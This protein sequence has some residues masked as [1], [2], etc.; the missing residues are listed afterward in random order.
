MKTI[1][2]IR[3]L[4]VCCLIMGGFSFPVGVQAQTYIDG[5]AE[6]C[7]GTSGNYTIMPSPTPG[8]TYTWNASSNGNITGSNI[9]GNITVSWFSAGGGNVSA[10]GKD[11]SG[12][13]LETLNFPVNV[14]ATPSPHIEWDVRVGCQL[15]DSTKRDKE[16]KEGLAAVAPGAPGEHIDDGP[17]VRVCENSIVKYWVTNPT[18]GPLTWSAPGGTIL[19]AS[20]NTC[21]VQWGS[22][23]YGSV[24]VTE[25]Y[26]APNETCTGTTEI[27]IEI[28]DGPKAAFHAVPESAGVPPDMVI[29]ACV[30]KDIYFVDDSDPD[31]GTPLVSWYWDFGDGTFSS[32]QDPVHAYSNP[33]T[34]EVTL[35][36]TNEC[37]CTS[38]IKRKVEVYPNSEPLVIECPSVVCEGA[39]V[40]YRL[41]NPP[42]KILDCIA[43]GIAYWDVIGG[44]ILTPVNNTFV[45]IRWDNVGPDGFGYVIFNPGADCGIECPAPTVVKVPVILNKGTIEGAIVVCPKGRQ[46]RYSLPQWPATL[47][48]WSIVTGTGAILMPSDQPN[49]IILVTNADGPVTIKATYQ[50]TLL[51]CGGTASIDVQVVP[52]VAIVGPSE[53]CVTDNY[54]F[55]LSTPYFADWSLSGP[56]GFLYTASGTSFGGTFSGGPGSYVL[57]VSGNSFCSPGPF[58]I[59]VLDIPPPPDSISGPDSTCAGIPVTF[60]AGAAAPGTLFEWSVSG[61]TLTGSNTGNEVTAIFNPGGP[62][63]ISVR[64]VTVESPNCPSAYI[65]HTVSIYNPSVTI[66]GTNPVCPNAA[67]NYSASYTDGDTY[68]WFVL[69][70]S[71]GSIASGDNT[72]NVQVLW[73][74][75]T[76]TVSAS[77]VVKMRRCNQ[78]YYDTLPVTVFLQPNIYVT[79]DLTKCRGEVFNLT[80]NYPAGTTFSSVTWTY[81]GGSSTGWPTPSPA[82]SFNNPIGSNTVNTITVTANDPN[83]CPSTVQ[84]TY[85]VTVKPSPVAFISP[86]GNF[87]IC[88]PNPINIPLT[89]TL[90]AGYEPTSTLEWFQGGSTVL[91]PCVPGPS[92]NSYTANAYGAYY[93]TATGVNGCTSNSDTVNVI[94]FCGG[95]PCTITPTP[96]VTAVQ[97]NTFNN[98][99]LIDITGSYNYTPIS[100]DWSYPNPPAIQLVSQTPTNLQL[101]A[102]NAGSYLVFYEVT[103]L[104]NLGN[105]CTV[106]EM[107]NA[108]VP[109]VTGIEYG[110]TCSSMALGYDV[111]VNDFS[112]IY[113]GAAITGY[114]YIIDGGTPVPSTASSYTTSLNA[115][116]HTL[117]IKVTYTYNG[118]SYTCYSD[119]LTVNLPALPMASF[120]ASAGV[121]QPVCV[122][123]P[124]VFTNTST[125]SPLQY[126]WDFGDGTSSTVQTPAKV[127]DATWSGPTTVTLTTT[128]TLGCI[129]QAS[130]VLNVVSNPLS[131][132]LSVAPGT[133]VCEGTPIT[134]SLS[135]SM[136]G[137]YQYDWMN[138]I[139]N[140]LVTAYQPVTVNESGNYWVKLYG[141]YG[142]SYY[143]GGVNVSVINMP[144]PVIVG[145]H[146][147]CQGDVVTLYGYSGPGV[148]YQWYRDGGSIFGATSETLSESGLMPGTYEYIV[149]I[150]YN[151]GTTTC[152]RKSG[153]FYVNINTPPPPPNVTYS[154]IDCNQYLI[155][156]SASASGPGTFT[157]SNG[158]TGSTIYVTQGGPYKVWFD[159]GSGCLS[160]REIDV[161]KDPEEYMWVFPTGCYNFCYQQLPKTL[162]GPIVPFTMWE[163][164]HSGGMGMSG[165]GYVSPYNI[166]TGGTYN[167]YLRNSWCD[168]TSGDMDVNVQDCGPCDFDFFMRIEAYHRED[169]T[170]YYVASG[171]FTNPYSFTVSATIS[172]PYGIF[173]PSTIT[174]P[175]GTSGYSTTFVPNSGYTGGFTGNITI[176]ATIADPKTG[177]VYY[178]YYT[179]TVYYPPAC[180]FK[181]RPGSVEP[182][183]DELTGLTL[184]PNPAQ[185]VVNVRYSFNK[186]AESRS[187]ELYDMTGR[188]LRNETVHDPNGSVDWDV[189]DYASGMYIVIMRQDGK[190]IQK[191]KLSITR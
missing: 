155:K 177:E 69:P 172:S 171:S 39:T 191:G 83:G 76:T 109:L 31:G 180:S 14:L 132:T 47:F 48:N 158:M 187:I 120:T 103:Y 115:G 146:D 175:F 150:T 149:E 126:F 82:I 71:A 176:T 159:D 2:M 57:N 93:V 6:V 49:E 27:C 99:G 139:N 74:N 87:A 122:G 163:W 36:V 181:S 81:P 168:R 131:A 184:A 72:P 147:Y 4:V 161:E 8:L 108:V 174:A 178:C 94:N 16:D 186:Q 128:N 153:P 145:A 101:E 117:Q 89:A 105:P 185:S 23:G 63:T 190:V 79:G 119:I 118:I 92:C 78:Y 29:T 62:H 35:T 37:N 130:A 11:G 41:S 114:D 91:G 15:T 12:N 20:G 3:Y 55:T 84:T 152:S 26:V 143:T 66:S 18:G 106:T 33:G 137:V 188:Q 157:W 96:T 61:G 68:E 164:M 77:V 102:E 179:T 44:T 125:P 141:N 140:F 58:N 40:T 123:Y 170:C 136:P 75:T 116:T 43:A 124:V 121:N 45:Q 1:Q 173:V 189:H 183:N 110:A 138:D 50:N 25:G 113:G 54:S 166:T 182:V 22:A 156:L 42:P 73:N 90:Q 148:T 86:G 38:T 64:R 70:A 56:G 21:T 162:Y 80:L 142:C 59:K 160:S 85:D 111:T 65:A 52:P 88:P 133:E 95:S 9:G 53:Y 100:T 60:T 134:L 46:Y 28:I 104:D 19:S 13:I 135:G 5:N 67:Y 34:Y 169:G 51:G 17:C 167:L 97:N 32:A 129:S 98:C 7:V 24:S 30:D 127:Y 165:S 151:N 144:D 112:T 154:V 107:V 10:E